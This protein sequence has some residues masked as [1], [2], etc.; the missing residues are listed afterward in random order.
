MYTWKN[1]QQTNKQR[2]SLRHIGLVKDHGKHVVNQPYLK[3]FH[4]C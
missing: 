4:K 2:L 1:N 3:Y